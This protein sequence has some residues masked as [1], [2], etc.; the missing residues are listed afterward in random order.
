MLAFGLG[1]VVLCGWAAAQ[2][3]LMA[4][5]AG[6]TGRA[7]IVLGLAAAVLLW[8]GTLLNNYTNAR[9]QLAVDRANTEMVNFLA[10]TLPPGQHVLLNI[11]SANEYTNQLALT[12]HDLKQRTD[13]TLETYQRQA[14]PAGDVVIM[15]AIENQPRLV[16]RMGVAEPVQKAWNED[17]QSTLA[18]GQ[19]VITYQNNQQFQ[20]LNL[21]YP[22]LL[23]PLLRRLDYCQV[24]SP[25]LDRS[26]F[27]YG[28]T[29]YQVQTVIQ[30]P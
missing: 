7:V 10:E 30:K 17:L 20:L 11:Q 16:V 9:I 8:A 27:T 26:I 18:T 28:W 6:P 24:V 25:L 1:L 21:D 2:S 22:R 13:I 12:L 14:I 5:E 23:C 4:R 15:P 29:V 3:V 19:T